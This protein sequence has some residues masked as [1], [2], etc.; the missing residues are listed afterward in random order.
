MPDSFIKML[1]KSETI[2]RISEVTYYNQDLWT[3]PVVSFYLYKT[4]NENEE[5]ASLIEK[6]RQKPQSNFASGLETVKKRLAKIS[7]IESFIPDYIQ[8][9]NCV[10]ARRNRLIEVFR[11]RLVAEIPN[12]ASINYSKYFS[13]RRRDESVKKSNGCCNN[14]IFN[15]PP[16]I[17]GPISNLLI[18]DDC[19]NSGSTVKCFLDALHDDGL[20]NAKTKISIYVI[21]TF[22]ILTGPFRTLNIARM[23]EFNSN[24]ELLNRSQTTLLISEN[25]DSPSIVIGAP[26]HAPGGTKN[27]P[28]LEHPD[29]DENTGVIA[30]RLAEISQFNSVIACNYTIDPN[31]DLSTDYSKQIIAWNPRFLIEIHGHGARKIDNDTIEVSSGRE[32]KNPWSIKFAEAM[33]SYMAQKDFLKDYKVLG[34]INHLHFK[35]RNTKTITHEGWISFH[36]EL[37]PSLRVDSNNNL[38]EESTIQLLSVLVATIKDVCK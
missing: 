25:R 21:Y 17:T 6:Y 11:E 18:I 24:E 38:P 2:G 5:V 31:K 7:P 8:V 35:A 29:S 3:A 27:L 26:H 9:F 22:Q 32:D 1:S 30:H 12:S 10:D 28:C 37:P 15:R 14:F 19:I 23:K 20:L 4:N 13:K 36:I 16:T 33:Q 34:D